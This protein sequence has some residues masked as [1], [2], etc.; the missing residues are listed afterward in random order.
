VTTPFSSSGGPAEPTVAFRELTASDDDRSLLRRFYETV[1]APEFPDP[2]EKESLA[3]IERYLELKQSG[4]YGDNAYHVVVVKTGSGIVGGAIA[5]YLAEPNAGVIEFLV[6][7]PEWRGRGL[8]R[9]L[10]DRTESWL[11]ADAQRAGR[12][13]PDW[14]VAEINDPFRVDLAADNLDPFLRARVWGGW[15]YRR[16]DLPY[17][18]PGLSES[19]RPVHHL[20]LAVKPLA[21]EYRDSLPAGRVLD[22]LRA[23]LRWAMRIPEPEANAEYR[24]MAAHLATRADVPAIPLERYVGLDP[25]ASLS[26]D[27][28]VA[29]GPDLDGA[30]AVYAD[31]FPPGA[32]ALDV[33]ALRQAVLHRAARPLAGRHHLW[34]LRTAPTAAVAGMA[35]FFSL[36][37]VGFGGYLA[38]S[39]ALRGRGLVRS[40]VARIEEQMRRDDTGARGWLIECEPASQALR[41]FGHLGFKEIAL[42]YRQPPLPGRPGGEADSPRLRLAYKEFGAVYRVPDLTRDEL[43]AA[44]RWVFRIVYD[45]AAPERS[46]WFLALDAQIA[47]WPREGVEWHQSPGNPR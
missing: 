36:P 13:H 45:I 29:A 15:G 9:R 42:D 2:E 5:D 14:I 20:L 43:R 19:Q 1:Y 4:W 11:A 26:I 32:T 30:L 37:G 3:N 18:Q 8:G 28:V 27:E 23:Y 31:A 10:L 6:V 21:R 47:A 34:A 25:S 35:S 16:L 24:A 40:V 39:S 7:A 41:V 44:L 46:P 17:V 22:T 12:P 38:L 33:P